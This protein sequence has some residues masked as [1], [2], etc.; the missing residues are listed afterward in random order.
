LAVALLSSC[1]EASGLGGE[2]GACAGDCVYECDAPTRTREV[3]YPDS[4]EDLELDT[5]WLNC[6]PTSRHAGTCIHRCPSAT[7]CNAL[8]GC[9]CRT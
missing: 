6:R 7:G 2:E 3:C 5:G 4:A 9:W 1:T 8:D